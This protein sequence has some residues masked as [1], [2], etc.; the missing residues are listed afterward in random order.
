MK[1]RVQSGGGEKIAYHA[2]VC[3]ALEESGQ[4]KYKIESGVSSGAISALWHA[5][6]LSSREFSNLVLRTTNDMVFKRWW[7]GWLEGIF[8]GSL[9][10]ASPLLQTL[11]ENYDPIRMVES[12]KLLR[13]G[14]VSLV[15]KKYHVATEKEVDLPLWC[16]RS[17]AHPIALGM[18]GNLWTDGGVRNV[19]PLRA[20]IKAGATDIDVILTF[21]LKRRSEEWKRS[22]WERVFK[23]VGRSLREIEIVIDE[24]SADDLRFCEWVNAAVRSG[25]PEARDKR[26]VNLRIFAPEKPLVMTKLQFKPDEIARVLAQGYEDAWRI[27]RRTT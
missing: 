24:A 6:G 27:I 22:W 4:A 5:Q 20:A 8:R 19:T 9:Y 17:A 11:R 3:L 12:S 14:A 21:P 2:G 10:N 26:E 25:A 13:M 7:F 1:A 23:L 15:D 16:W 18:K